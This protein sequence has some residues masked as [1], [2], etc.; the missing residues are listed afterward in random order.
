M[1]ENAKPVVYPGFMK[2]MLSRFG[3]SFFTTAHAQTVS[4]TVSDED[5]KKLSGFR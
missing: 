3:F 1:K 4:G 2:L 5:G